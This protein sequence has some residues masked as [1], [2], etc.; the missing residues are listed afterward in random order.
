M[1][2]GLSIQDKSLEP[3]LRCP[4]L[5]SVAQAHLGSRAC[6]DL[7]RPPSPLRVGE[8]VQAT[9]TEDQGSLRVHRNEGGCPR[10]PQEVTVTVD[11]A[12]TS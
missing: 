10:S 9:A 2:Q 8:P 4:P 11:E 1:S 6:R 12:L 5:P 3:A 7:P